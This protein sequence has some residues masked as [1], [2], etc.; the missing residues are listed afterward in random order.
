MAFA[1][2]RRHS[3][4]FYRFAAILLVFVGGA[5]W[6]QAPAALS[7]ELRRLVDTEKWQLDLQIS[8]KA[9]GSGQ[10]KGLGGDTSYTHT[11]NVEYTETVPL[12]SHSS[13][14][15]V[16]MQ[17]LTSMAGDPAKAA[18]LNKA[19]MDI[20]MQGDNIGSWMT[21][22]PDLG[23]GDV[24]EA[25]FKAFGERLMNTAIGKMTLDFSEQSRGERLTTEVGTVY[26]Q[27]VRTTARGTAGVPL[28]GQQ[29]SFEL[30]GPAKRV[31]LSLPAFLEPIHDTTYTREVVTLTETPPGSKPTETRETNQQPLNLFPGK[32]TITEAAA[33]L[34]ESI[35]LIDD[36]IALAG[37]K[38]SGQRTT[39]ATY[40]AHGAPVEGT[41][42]VKY[43][44]T[45]R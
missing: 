6:A 41:L 33:K 28:G 15:S 22:A 42:A 30:N 3:A 43:T 20:V 11:L 25:Q 19:M 40:Q 8:F 26:A 5:A 4:P 2:L 31:L 37:G 44:L 38:I 23:D 13:G 45:P 12:D 24:S 21:G 34:G 1:C 27:T 16:S 32:L 7:P 9:T 17:R 36:P 35:L 18:Q 14:A 29:I 39:K 10:A